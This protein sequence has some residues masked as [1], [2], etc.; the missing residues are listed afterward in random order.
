[1]IAKIQLKLNNDVLLTVIKM[2]KQTDDYVVEN[3]TDALLISVKEDLITKLE[4]KAKNIQKQVSIL[5]HNKKHSLVLKYHEAYSLYKLVESV[6]EKGIFND[7]PHIKKIKKLIN[8]LHSKV[9]IFAKEDDFN[10]EEEETIDLHINSHQQAKNV[11]FPELFT[12]NDV[13]TN[14]EENSQKKFKP[15]KEKTSSDLATEITDIQEDCEPD[16]DRSSDHFLPEIDIQSNVIQFRLDGS[17]DEITPT[18]EVEHSNSEDDVVT[19]EEDIKVD[20]DQT[21]VNTV[22]ETTIVSINNDNSNHTDPK[23]IAYQESL[24]DDNNLILEL[25]VDSDT[26]SCTNKESISKSE[27]DPFSAYFDIQKKGLSNEKRDDLKTAVEIPTINLQQEVNQSDESEL[28]LQIEVFNTSQDSLND[29]EGE[30]TTKP[31]RKKK[32]KKNNSTSSEGQI[33]LF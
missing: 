31:E 28:N 17:Y 14:T 26:N 19:K 3:V 33:S 12:F 32:E 23:S 22:E 27:L 25:T 7:S 1:M 5:D 18:R 11:I 8:E 16:Q 20:V 10:E 24:D 30:N 2:I 15:T 13:V 21:I 6:E 9:D 29:S 4:D